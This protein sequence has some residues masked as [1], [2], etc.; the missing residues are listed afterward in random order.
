[1]DILVLSDVYSPRINGLSTS[2]RAFATWCGKDIRSR[3]LSRL[4]RDQAQHAR[5]QFG[6]AF[7]V[8]RLPSNTIF[9][10]HPARIAGRRQP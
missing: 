3:W 1:M 4:R 7:Q 9:F 5:D 6:E 10:R 8:L 2:I